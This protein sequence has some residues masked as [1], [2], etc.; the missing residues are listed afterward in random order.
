MAADNGDGAGP[1][2]AFMNGPAHDLESLRDPPVNDG[3]DPLLMRDRIELV[4]PGE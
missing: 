1:L 2:E 4:P 3:D